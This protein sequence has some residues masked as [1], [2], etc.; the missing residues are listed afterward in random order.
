ML[1]LVK[2]LFRS[3]TPGNTTRYK[4]R[5]YEVL[6]DIWNNGLSHLTFQ[7]ICTCQFS[8]NRPRWS[9][10]DSRT[11][12]TEIIRCYSC[13]YIYFLQIYFVLTFL[14]FF[15]LGLS[16]ELRKSIPWRFMSSLDSRPSLSWSWSKW[17]S[18]MSL[19]SSVSNRIRTLSAGSLFSR[20]VW[21][22]KKKYYI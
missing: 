8:N 4:S 16:L 17:K 18:S 3:K 5:F 6:C 7:S 15:F 11:I 10:S 14:P 22:Y 21:S 13:V 9:E 1:K 2:L 20:Y 12:T 19:P